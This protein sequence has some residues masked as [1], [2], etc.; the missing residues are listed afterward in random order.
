MQKKIVISVLVTF[1][2]TLL[3]SVPT[4]AVLAE[5]SGDTP[6]SGVTSYIKQ[7]YDS[8]VTLTYGSDAGGG[9]GNW[10]AMWNRIRSA[11]EWTPAG[12]ATADEVADG[13]TFYSGS[14]SL[15]TGNAA[16]GPDWS[17][18][19]LQDYDDYRGYRYDWNTYEWITEDEDNTDEESVWVHT[20]GTED[21]GVWQD[22]R[23]GLYWSADQGNMTNLFTRVQTVPGTYDC[24]F[25]DSD[26]RGSYTGGDEDC[27]D[28]INYCATLELDADGDA[29]DDVGWYLPSQKELMQASIDGM[30]NQTTP[31][32]TGLYRGET[33]GYPLYFWSATELSVSD[34]N[35]WVV[36]TAYGGAGDGGE[37]GSYSVRCAFRD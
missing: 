30:Y 23:T 3:I 31:D 21:A 18:Q 34:S 37:D 10:G 22:T 28:A 1:L 14:R 9:W 4:T 17:K 19:S 6:D 12:T 15:Q 29:V 7:I 24:P 26:P 2:A 33:E 35:T 11:A 8:L 36:G 16:L 20:S 5:Q 32:F 27:G 13:E 25:F